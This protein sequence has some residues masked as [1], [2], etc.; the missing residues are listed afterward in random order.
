MEW[1]Y[2]R[3]ELFRESDELRQEFQLFIVEEVIACRVYAVAARVEGRRSWAMRC[4]ISVCH[5]DTSPST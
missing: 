5:R 2:I 3:E 1:S 4:S